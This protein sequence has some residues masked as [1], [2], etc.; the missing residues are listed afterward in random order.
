[1]PRKHAQGRGCQVE[2][3]RNRNRGINE[4]KNT[5]ITTLRND[6]ESLRSDLKLRKKFTEK[7][8]DNPGHEEKSDQEIVKERNSRNRLVALGQRN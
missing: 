3:K 8:K 5:K 1:M 4:S 2:K 7:H 6:I